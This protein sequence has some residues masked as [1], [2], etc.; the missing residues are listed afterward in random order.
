MSDDPI[1]ALLEAVAAFER[2]G[3]RYAVGGSVA[4]SIHGEPRMTGDADVVVEL[5]PTQVANLVAAL[6]PGFY[7]DED[8]VRDAVARK[9]SF[10]AIH[11]ASGHKI[12]AFVAGGDPLDAG[13]LAR[14]ERI[15]LPERPGGLLVSAAEDVVLR[16][17]SWF[18]K[19]GESSERQWRDVLGVLK[20]QGARLDRGYLEGTAARI[21]LE[22]LLR[23]AL[24]ESGLG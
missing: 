6:A 14:A 16:K 9:A 19:G 8:A 15:D 7:V 5:G 11:F 10:N 3:I 23:R 24:D 1:E 20:Q 17:L 13:Q 2:L 12:D 18:R 4:S 22:D 21:G